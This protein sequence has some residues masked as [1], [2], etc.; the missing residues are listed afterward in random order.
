M[1]TYCRTC[2]KE[3]YV[4]PQLIRIGK[5]KY[6]SKECYYKGMKGGTKYSQ[7]SDF[8]KSWNGDMSYI[9]GFIYAD[10]CIHKPKKGVQSNILHIVQKDKKILEEIREKIAPNRPLH[11]HSYNS[12]QLDIPD[13]EIVKDLEKLGVFERKTPVKEFPDVPKE[14]LAD[15][16]RGYFDGDG[17]ILLESNANYFPTLRISIASGS[18]KFL[19]KMETILKDI[20]IISYVN[21]SK[22]VGTVVLRMTTFNALKFGFFIYS[23]KSDIK[24]DRKFKRFIEYLDKRKNNPPKRKY[25]KIE[26]LIENEE[27]FRGIEYGSR[28]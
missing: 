13:N 21:K 25:K 27:R 20:E 10:G 18:F 3:F 4:Y 2:G 5:G 14:Y 17:S 22:N 6:C 9:L 11:I 19:K 16:I 12:Y 1:K 7:N 26:Q 15:F 28:N 23:G 24:I 8:F